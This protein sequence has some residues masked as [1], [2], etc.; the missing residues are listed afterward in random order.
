MLEDGAEQG[1]TFERN[2]GAVGHGVDI[3]ISD[4]ESDTTPATFWI[5]NPKNTWIENV[6]AG[7]QFSGFWFE[8]KTRVRGP[9]FAMHE[10]MVPN[11]LELLH[12][13]D[14]VSHS[15]AQ[16]LQTYPQA[17]YRP[18]NLAVFQ[19][20]KSYRNRGSGIFFHAGGRLGIDGGY[21]SDNKIG[22]DIDMDHSDV[23]SNTKIVGSSP[24]YEAVVD[25]IGYSASKYPA[26]SLC[27]DDD[28]LV[29]V[30]LDSYHDG[31]L[32][33]ATGSTLMNVTFSGFGT[34]NCA[35]SS[36]LHVD[37]E[38]IQYFDTRNTLE[39]INMLD[40]S[41]RVNL[42]GGEQQVAI[43]DV[44][45]SMMGE[46]GYIV[47]D[48]DAIRAHPSCI[49]V[50]N[51]CAA[52]CPGICLRTMTVM[53]PSYY[54][55]GELTLNVTGSTADGQII[56]PIS[57][58]DFQTK[59]MLAPDKDSSQGRLFVTLPAG[60]SYHGQFFSNMDGQRVWPHYTDLKY[61]DEVDN[62]GQDFAS[63]SI[64]QLVPSPSQCDSLIRNGDFDSG[65]TDFW[66]YAGNF[67]ME[68]I[69]EGA[70]SSKSLLAP[71]PNNGGRHVGLG[72]F[73]DTRCIE[74]GYIY[75]LSANLK[76]EDTSTGELYI[77]NLNGYSSDEASC[78]R[79]NIRFTNR[80][81]EPAHKWQTAGQMQS[82]N[83]EWNLMT[84]SY[85]ADAFDASAYSVYLYITGVPAG[86][87]I[88][89]DDVS[90]VRTDQTSS[91]TD[92][93]STSPTH[94]PSSKASS[95]PSRI[96]VPVVPSPFEASNPDSI[97]FGDGT[98]RLATESGVDSTV[99]TKESHIGD[100]VLTVEIKSRSMSGSGYQPQLVLFVASETTSIDDV[101]TND[102]GFG[103]FFEP[104]VVAWTKE[105][106]YFNPDNPESLSYTWFDAKVLGAD[107]N[108]VSKGG[109]KN[110]RM[111][112]GF[113]RLERSGGSVDSYYSFDGESWT[114]FGGGSVLLP[115]SYQT[116]P[117]KLGYRIKREWKSAY[118]ITTYPSIVSDGAV[119]PGTSSGP[120][121]YFI[122]GNTETIGTSCSSEGCTLALDAYNSAMLS[123]ETFPGDVIFSVKVENREIFGSGYQSGLALFF[124][125]AD[126]TIN[127]VPTGRNEDGAFNEYVI[128]AVSDKI[129][130]TIDHTWTSMKSQ[131]E[132]GLVSQSGG[133]GY[134]NTDGYLKLERTGN[135]VSA[136]MSPNGIGWKPIGLPKTL[137][138][139][140]AGAPIKLGIRTFRNWCSSYNISVMPTVEQS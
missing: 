130:P 76:L 100:I 6:A 68:L 138:S 74:E 45:G 104:S 49:S 12:F 23:I 137:P 53:V 113:L 48:S 117:L 47:S 93:P 35:G 87:N 84:G 10:E 26:T 31:T 54:G 79:G 17:G 128:A 13:V 2:V 67:G 38:N 122:E 111:N 51:A 34:G 103:D 105:K 81:G 64:D 101:T 40:D 20:H 88:Q 116:A 115:E 120:Q 75:T 25:A 123:T 30:R 82:N 99:L 7:S 140:Y 62:C 36:A 83:L 50:L 89:I 52:F 102:N 86:I 60:G 114:P 1:N 92:M 78:P 94:P 126:A 80:L 106:I 56:S 109:S 15:N 22:I 72:Q 4:D 118:D 27:G 42:C 8:V 21:I 57:V 112:S 129:Y 63:F 133:D 55:R 58:Q 121:S 32:F 135:V 85:V 19:N 127:S 46:P 24:A 136:F 134:K 16:G 66:W 28:G 3:R 91:P 110:I 96:P 14:N 124:T 107:E 131:T 98:I 39:G 139:N 77:C 44:D 65:T 61:E 95:P 125:A 73:L 33:G 71:N 11:K 5:T 69:N 9:S 70:G 37:S 97:I 41:P 119:A 132:S 59:A 90:F 29:G 18:E 43:R 108:Y